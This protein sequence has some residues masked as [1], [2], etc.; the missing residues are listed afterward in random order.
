MPHRAN[1]KIATTI[2]IN[3]FHA[4]IRKRFYSVQKWTYLKKAI[5]D[6]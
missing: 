2:D 4:A 3:Q 6:V 5:V 1:M